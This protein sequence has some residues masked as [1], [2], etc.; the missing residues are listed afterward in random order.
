MNKKINIAI[1]YVS[2]NINGLEAIRFQRKINK[3]LEDIH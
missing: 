2:N 3:S 1:Y